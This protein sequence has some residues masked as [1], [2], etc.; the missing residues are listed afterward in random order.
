M[1]FMIHYKK[2][3]IV[4]IFIFLKKNFLLGHVTHS[5]K[6]KLLH[7]KARAFS[8]T[9]LD[10]L[11]T[12][13]RRNGE[14][15]RAIVERERKQALEIENLSRLSLSRNSPTDSSSAAD[16]KRKSRSMS[17]LAGAGARR[18]TTRRDLSTGSARGTTPQNRNKSVISH[19]GGGMRKSDTSKSMS[20][21]SDSD[22]E[23]MKGRARIERSRKLRQQV[24]EQLSNSSVTG[25]NYFFIY[26]TLPAPFKMSN[27]KTLIKHMAYWDKKKFL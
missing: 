18:S 22:S 21:L 11:A 10:Q 17:Q 14:H 7:K 1:I 20:Q 26:I 5:K 2:K 15:I 12:P 19:A 25:A 27:A 13:V 6:K 4:F 8:M 3:I 16:Q 24:K 9:R 23:M